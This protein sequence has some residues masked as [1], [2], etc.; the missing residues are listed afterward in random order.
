MV[1]ATA[2]EVELLRRQLQELNARMEEKRQLCGCCDERGSDGTH[3][4]CEIDGEVG[5]ETA[6]RGHESREA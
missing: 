5:D 2:Q 1:L 4:C 3:R 6:P